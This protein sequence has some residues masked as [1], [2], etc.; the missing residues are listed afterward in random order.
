MISMNSQLFKLP[1]AIFICEL[2]FLQIYYK[3][4]TL[5]TVENYLFK[6]NKAKLMFIDYNLSKKQKSCL[7]E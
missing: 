5:T 4:T 7:S 3:K 2:Y 6:I 1:M